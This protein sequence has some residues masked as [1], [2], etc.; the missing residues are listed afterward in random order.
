MN[1]LYVNY[2]KDGTPVADCN[3]EERVLQ[4]ASLCVN[5]QDKEWRVS[6]EN[7]IN[8]VR[9]MKLTGKITCNLEIMFEGHLLEMNR[10][11]VIVNGYPYGFCDYIDRWSAALLTAQMSL[12]KS[13]IELLN[14]N[15]NER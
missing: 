2:A 13:H 8:C 10:Y 12:K 15:D 1:T 14:N 6:T 11:C 9:M 7:V 3:V 4:N 5:G